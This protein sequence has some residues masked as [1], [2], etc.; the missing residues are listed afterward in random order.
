MNAS[1]ESRRIWKEDVMR[2][3]VEMLSW[4]LPEW[5]EEINKT[6]NGY[7]VCWHRFKQGIIT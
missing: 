4:E 3:V 1:D 6:L 2:Y 7:P 5:T